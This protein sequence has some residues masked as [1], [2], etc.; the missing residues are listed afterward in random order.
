MSRD[1]LY[2]SAVQ[3]EIREILNYYGGISERLA[4]DRRRAM[5]ARGIGEIICGMV[6]R[7]RATA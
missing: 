1:V 6:F 3:V 7:R 4:D 5:A 2:H